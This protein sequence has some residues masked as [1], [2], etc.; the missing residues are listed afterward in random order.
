MRKQKI[1]SG[2]QN[3]HQIWVNW[4]ILAVGIN[5][6][7]SISAF[8]TLGVH[9]TISNIISADFV[10]QFAKDIYPAAYPSGHTTLKQRGFNA[11]STSWRWINVVSTLCACCD[12]YNWIPY[13][14][15]ILMIKNE[16]G[17]FILC[18]YVKK[19]VGWVGNSV[20][21]ALD[22]RFLLRSIC[23]STYCGFD[24]TKRNLFP[25]IGLTYAIATVN[26]LLFLYNESFLLFST[27]LSIIDAL[28]K[29]CQNF[30]NFEQEELVE[31]LSLIYLPHRILYN[32]Q[33]I[34]LCSKSTAWVANTEDND[35]TP[36]NAASDLGLHYLS[37]LV[38][39]NIRV[40]M[41]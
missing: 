15:T 13:L 26:W 30:R 41:A 38:C 1:A 35:Q 40:K 18:R 25:S 39:P 36:Q 28:Q 34:L 33:S 8:F 16:Q 3:W 9:H 21:S 27:D 31:N 10:T 12:D 5:K 11:D 2:R 4:Q 7:D 17:R 23:T 32:L 22:L 6:F 37:R 20:D 14:L 19:T 29:Y 24:I